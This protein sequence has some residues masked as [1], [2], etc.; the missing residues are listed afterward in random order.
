MFYDAV[1]ND[2]GLA[3][4]PIKAIVAPRPI[5]WVSTLTTSG[6]ANLA[7]YS[8]FNLISDNPHFVVLGSSG[9]KDTLRNIEIT[10]EFTV[11]LVSY[12]LREAMNI[13]CA[14]FPPH[15]DEFEQARLTKAPGEFIRVPRVAEALAALECVLHGVHPL[16]KV[17]G[18]VD[19]WLVVGRV[20]GIYVADSVIVD[21]RV[22]AHKLQLI[23]RMG[24]SEYVSA[25]TV[26]RMR[27]P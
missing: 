20:L 15:V 27:R 6:S 2:H 21:G 4:D 12:D 11:N 5:G 25:N 7:P 10:R 19:N 17:D 9:Y 26:W 3:L 16:P 1:K 22:S 14:A 23:A 8:F 24:Y 13:T 18:H